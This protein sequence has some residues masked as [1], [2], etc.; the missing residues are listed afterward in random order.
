MALMNQTLEITCVRTSSALIFEIS[1]CMIYVVL[2][3]INI[4]CALQDNNGIMEGKIFE[5]GAKST[6]C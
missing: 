6:A 1:F 4:I 3:R 5:H 2:A